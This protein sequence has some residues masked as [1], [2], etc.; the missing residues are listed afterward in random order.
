MN[1]NSDLHNQIA[2]QLTSDYELLEVQLQNASGRPILLVRI[3]RADEQ[4]VSVDDIEAVTRRLS[5]WL[6]EA[7][8]VSGEYRLEVESPGAKRPLL[9][10][11]HF[12]RMLGLKAKVRGGE[13]SFTAPIKAVDGDQ[14]TFDVPGQGDV[15]L[16]IADIKANLAEFPSE[17]R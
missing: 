5:N 10:E 8:P 3:D 14:V 15:T 11:R 6:D 1:N 12:E 16:R 4:P 7:D 13:H 9:R 2:Q 17:H